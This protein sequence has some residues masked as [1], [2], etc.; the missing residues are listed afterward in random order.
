MTGISAI[1]RVN[2][3]EEDIRTEA[4]LDRKNTE[5]LLD[6][7]RDGVFFVD[8]E[9]R[10]IFWNKGAEKLSGYSGSEVAGRNCSDRILNPVDEAGKALCDR[11]CPLKLALRDRK[12]HTIEAYLHHK[13]GYRLPASFRAFPLI[14]GEGKML[15]AAQTFFDISPK[16]FMP[17]RKMEL[18]KMQLLDRMT[19]VGN[20]RFLEIHIQSKLDEI[21]RYRL[22]FGLLCIDVDRLGKLNETYG[23]MVGDQALRLVSQ[24]VLNNS[25]FF[26]IVG[27]WQSD[28][29]MVI[30]V[31]LDESKLDFVANKLRL[32]VESS[33]LLVDEKL[34]RVTVSIGATLARRVDSLEILLERAESLMMHS[35]W[36]GRNK[37]SSKVEK[38]EKV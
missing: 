10:I 2:A 29:F 26:D 31:N 35:K 9:C 7:I 4:K 36:L 18:E 11:D 24:T 22:S 6:N 15:G 1:L 21:K 17:Q 28:E 37:V 32:L 38:E 27:R 30:A 20:R 16:F 12:V 23:E 14:G 5:F 3:M 25:R 33:N 13:E 8:T 34:I 19:E